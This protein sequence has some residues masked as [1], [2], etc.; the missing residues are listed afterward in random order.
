MFFIAKYCSEFPMLL[1]IF[2][3]IYTKGVN[4]GSNAYRTYW[5]CG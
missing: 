1:L 3:P 4:Y 2:A 5:H